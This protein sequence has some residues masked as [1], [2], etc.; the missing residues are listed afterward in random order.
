M[1]RSRRL[2]RAPVST[3]RTRPEWRGFVTRSQACVIATLG[4]GASEPVLAAMHADAIGALP[5]LFA[6]G[7]G[8]IG[9]ET[10][11]AF[12][13][14]AK[15]FADHRTVE[16]RRRLLAPAVQGLARAVDGFLDELQAQAAGTERHRADIHDR[17]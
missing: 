10:A 11:E 8:Q 9:V 15:H 7:C 2:Q 17:D 1:K 12:A 6:L 5:G 3:L 13:K 16:G 14:V 4:D